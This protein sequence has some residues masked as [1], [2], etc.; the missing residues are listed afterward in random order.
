MQLPD[1]ILSGQ[2]PIAVVSTT[3]YILNLFKLNSSLLQSKILEHWIESPDLTA[4]TIPTIRKLSEHITKVSFYLYVF[5]ISPIFF[6]H[7][8][9]NKSIKANNYTFAKRILQVYQIL[10]GKQ[11]FLEMLHSES[12]LQTIYLCWNKAEE[13]QAEGF[14]SL[15]E[16]I[17]LTVEQLLE[18]PQYRTRAGILF[19]RLFRIVI[20]ESH[21]IPTR[22]K[23]N[24]LYLILCYLF[25]VQFII[26]PIYMY[27]CILFSFLSLLCS[28]LFL[29]CSFVSP[30]YC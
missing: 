22:L 29:N 17:L 21:T 10:S 18:N 8:S 1:I 5:V 14:E 20:M 16:E 19:P 3:L 12:V 15:V 27:F 9:I 28:V 6:F 13:K 23:A 2:P 26:C 11:E 24:G 30:V 4:L 25:L 7:Y